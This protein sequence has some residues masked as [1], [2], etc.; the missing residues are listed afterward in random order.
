MKETLGIT[1]ALADESRLR[2]LM[3][4]K[5]HEVCVCQIVE[6]L[7]SAFSTISKHLSILK[8]AGLIESR[9]KGRW[10]YYHLPQQPS[11]AADAAVSWIAE[12]LKGC[13]VI[14]QDRTKGTAVCSQVPEELAR[15]QRER[16][17]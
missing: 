9:K 11:A 8:S 12:S 3:M 5:D 7:G 13:D 16:V 17:C 10:V 4:V 2:I 15:H 14:A 1:K 6:V